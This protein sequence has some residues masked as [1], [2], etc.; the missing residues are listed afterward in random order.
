MSSGVVDK[1]LGRK[2]QLRGK[3]V[4]ISEGTYSLTAVIKGVHHPGSWCDVSIIVLEESGSNQSIEVPDSG[5]TRC[6]T[7]LI[8]C[9]WGHMNNDSVERMKNAYKRCC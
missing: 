4:E 7:A 9:W 1:W 8:G 2:S 3:T 6:V 5:G